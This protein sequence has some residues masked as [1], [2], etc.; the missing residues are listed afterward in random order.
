M[1]RI[2]LGLAGLA[3]LIVL[4]A[5]VLWFVARPDFA[6]LSPLGLLALHGVPPASLW[7]AVWVGLR[8]VRARRESRERTAEDA[9]RQ[10]R[11][12]AV[13]LSRR[14]QREAL[15]RRRTALPV[16][17]AV[18]AA[19]G[20]RDLTEVLVSA[21]DAIVVLPS[22]EGGWPEARDDSEAGGL[23]PVIER[24]LLE[25][26]AVCPVAM[27]FPVRIACPTNLAAEPMIDCVRMVVSNHWDARADSSS[28]GV[29]S[30]SPRAGVPP[31]VSAE[32]LAEGEHPVDS[33][34]TVF[35]GDPLL[36]GLVLLAVD[37]P[38]MRDIHRRGDAE[39]LSEAV[40]AHRRRHGVPAQAVIAFVVGS[41]RLGEMLSS[42][43]ASGEVGVTVRDADSSAAM[44]PFWEAGQ[45]VP[46]SLEALAALDPDVRAELGAAIPVGQVHRAEAGQFEVRPGRV[47][48]LA[49]VAR[50]IL[51]CGLVNA[52]Q[53]PMPGLET[54]VPESGGRHEDAQPSSA[55]CDWLIHNAGG[56]DVAG[57]RLAAVSL[58]MHQLQIDLNPIDEATNFPAALGDV[59]VALPLAMLAQ[60]ANKA[61][62]TAA[63]TCWAHFV[64]EGT[65]HMG[66]LTPGNRPLSGGA[67]GIG[68]ER[69]A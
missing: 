3:A 28:G 57:E 13:A 19:D 30:S 44:R 63:P 45:V 21:N 67:A 26:L 16:L 34:F 14:Q 61:A 9:E 1:A 51:E 8:V 11:E 52:G 59:G 18:I 33:L 12:L 42:V 60:A 10:E 48:A 27:A 2:A 50:R 55:S 32:R 25:T 46:T 49:G 37:S 54:D 62:E 24:V 66:M 41:P 36:P 5:I 43:E 7:V 64:G 56:V 69:A 4:W 23:L 20:E 47:G 22:D 35:D 29:L 58:A 6:A 53:L 68:L 39:A 17:A 15:A 31:S 65:L 38:R 40:R